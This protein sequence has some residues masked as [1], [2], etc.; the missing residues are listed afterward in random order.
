MKQQ[1]VIDINQIYTS[2]LSVGCYRYVH[3]V[4]RST[5]CKSSCLDNQRLYV[6]RPITSGRNLIYDPPLLLW[7]FNCIP[8]DLQ[9]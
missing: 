6:Y 4:I 8:I 9:Q 1:L 2:C 3:L 7:S 5:A